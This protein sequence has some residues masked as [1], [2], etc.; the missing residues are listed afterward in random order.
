VT[1]SPLSVVA[2]VSATLVVAD[3]MRLRRVRWRDV[4]AFSGASALWVT[5]GSALAASSMSSLPLHMIFHIIVMFVA[6]IAYL[7]GG[8][9]RRW[10]W[11]APVRLRRRILRR[12]Y[13]LVRP[14]R[15]RPIALGVVGV[16][17]V[18]LVMVLSHM[19]IVFNHAMAST[20]L[21]EGVVE[22]L[23]FASGL[24]FFSSLVP[25]APR[26]LRGP[27]RLQTAMVGI[28]MA[29]MLVLAMA[30]SIFTK[31]AWYQMAGTTMGAMAMPLSFH[32]QQLAA[33]V[34]WVCGDVWAVP[35]LVVI[36]RRL[37]AR[38]GSFFAALNRYSADGSLP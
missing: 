11:Y 32:D 31:A 5:T 6:P 24:V 9:G 13:R 17:F 30:M 22:P 16:V 25:A 18:N 12:W 14:L 3:A 19:P 4:V 29:E 38:D 37:L 7:Y 20:T 1:L 10:W 2:M 35:L 23:F 15:R 8:I 36:V 34:L 33:A 28:T 21:Y 27:L 26:R